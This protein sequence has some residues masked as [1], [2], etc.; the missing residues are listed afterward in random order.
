MAQDQSNSK[1][2][3]NYQRSGVPLDINQMW[4]GSD[5]FYGSTQIDGD[6]RTAINTRCTEGNSMDRRKGIAVWGGGG[7]AGKVYA[8]MVLQQD[9]TGD[10]L[11]RLVEGD[12]AGVQLQS[13]NPDTDV[14]DD[15]GTNIGTADDRRDFSWVCEQIGGEARVYFTNGVTNL[16]YTNG[17]T[18]TEVS[19][20]TGRY[21]TSYN[22]V[23]IMGCM[24]SVHGTNSFIWSQGG[25]HQFY[26]DDPLVDY[27]TTDYKFEVSGVI[28]AI[29]SFNWM[30]YIF[31]ESDGLY[32]FDI[33]GEQVP[34]KVSTHGT[35]SPKS[36]A[37]GAD[38]MFWADQYGIWYL[39]IGGSIQKISKSVDPIFKCITGD[40][41][42]DL[43]GG[44]NANEQ[45]EIHLG[46]LTYQGTEYSKVILLYEIEQSRFFGRNIWRWDTDKFFAN[47]IVTWANAFGFLTTFYGSRLTQTVYQTDYGYADVAE[48]IEMTWISKDFVLCDDKKE[49]T[50]EDF[51]IKYEP[52]GSGDIPIVLSA[53]MDTGDWVTVKTFN[54]E[55]D[56]C[57]HRTMRIQA[58][59]GLTGRTFALKI[60]SDSSLVTKIREILVTHSYNSSE[61]RL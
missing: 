13:Y 6:V 10:V 26:S 49:V 25:T 14:W 48:T 60:V 22:G 44:V 39:P 21:I 34:R 54:L 47:N 51:Y 12:G 40:N 45:Y 24:T 9:T 20:V 42:Y 53:R 2:D 46:D 27:L 61:Q 35:M 1:M 23:L 43:V 52:L 50:I 17:T 16:R 58:P 32:E 36:V 33:A 31:T 57:S 3:N 15:I 29:K 41:F 37:I 56:S 8:Q 18:V 30:V 7:D 5:H 28:T 11:L 59:M 4:Q 19:D 38:A 55:T